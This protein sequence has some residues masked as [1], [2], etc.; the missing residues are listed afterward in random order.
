M[1]L[2]ASDIAFAYGHG[3]RQVLRA[4]AADIAPGSFLAILGVNGCG[5]STF[6]D[7]LDGMLAPQRGCVRLGGVD[8]ESIDR[9]TRA[10]SIAY[11]AQHSHAN[12]L[13]VYDALLLGRKPFVKTGPSEDDFAIVDAVI[14]DMGLDDLAFRYVDELS[15]G[16]YQKV[17]IGRALVQCR[18]VLLLDEPT[19]N[20]DIA[21]QIEVMELVRRAVDERAIAAAAVMHDI[22]LSLSYCD[23][24]LVLKQ[25]EA[26]AYGG[27][28]VVTEDLLKDVYGITADIIE[29]NG[30][31]VVVPYGRHAGREDL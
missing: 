19:N 22:N 3:G 2:E 10:Q 31:R 1:N 15:G 11:V 21:N 17:V 5:K 14:A 18:D 16:E 23:R 24:F 6:L 4:V 25:G 13:V 29:W 26:A 27:P 8:L 28:E 9:R 12:R 20:L 30:K 7:C